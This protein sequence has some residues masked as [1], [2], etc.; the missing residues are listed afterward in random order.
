MV[1]LQIAA[2][3]SKKSSPTVAL[4]TALYGPVS[5]SI[6]VSEGCVQSESWAGTFLAY[7]SLGSCGIVSQHLP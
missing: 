1:L 6:K 3:C 4:N 5:P 7:T 2:F